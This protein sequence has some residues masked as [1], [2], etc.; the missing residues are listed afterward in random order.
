M[1]SH[2]TN[3]EII[4]IY[5]FKQ[6][7]EKFIVKKIDSVIQYH[8]L[9]IRILFSRGVVLKNGACLFFWGEGFIGGGLKR[10]NRALLSG[11]FHIL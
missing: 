6:N 3:K 7:K 10:E 1:E 5:I 9:S 8:V 2:I 4:K 11:F